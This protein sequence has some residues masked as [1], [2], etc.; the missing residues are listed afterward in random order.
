MHPVVLIPCVDRN[1]PIL[2]RHETMKRD[3]YSAWPEQR[4][5]A[6]RKMV[7]CKTRPHSDTNT[8]LT[9]YT[10]HFLWSVVWKRKC[11]SMDDGKCVETNAVFHNTVMQ[12]SDVNSV[13]TWRVNSCWRTRSVV[14][15]ELN[16]RKVVECCVQLPWCS[17][18]CQCEQLVLSH[19]GKRQDHHHQLSFNHHSINQ[20]S[21]VIIVIIMCK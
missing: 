4:S 11:F 9:R 18:G 1:F 14:D 19:P 6:V 13:F 16:K 17:Y 20:S 7:L 2:E 12:Y 5:S 15:H 3:K 10:K 8:H 21:I